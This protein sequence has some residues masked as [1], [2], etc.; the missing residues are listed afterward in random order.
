MFTNGLFY[1]I[2]VSV[3]VLFFVGNRITDG[4]GEFGGKTVLTM[5]KILGNVSQNPKVV[6][7]GI[8]AIITVVVAMLER[9]MA[10]PFM[11][12]RLYLLT[13]LSVLMVIIVVTAIY[14]FC[15]RLAEVVTYFWPIIWGLDLT[16]KSR[17][18]AILMLVLIAMGLVDVKKFGR[19]LDHLGKRDSTMRWVRKISAERKAWE[20]RRDENQAKLRGSRRRWDL[21]HQ[22]F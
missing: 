9:Q 8:F 10:L 11:R 5:M 19:R 1:M 21:S 12:N 22:R 14:Y 20:K 7:S 18:V 4:S 3:L 15:E 16:P 6:L 2:L 13:A 17:V